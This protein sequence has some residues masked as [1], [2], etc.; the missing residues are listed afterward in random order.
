M[1]NTKG[2]AVGLGCTAAVVVLYL[3]GTLVAER[4]AKEMV[5][6]SIAIIE[7]NIADHGK[8]GKVTYKEVR[9]AKFQLKPMASLI[10]PKI[11]INDPERERDLEIST[12][13]IR[14]Q[15]KTMDM[16]SYVIDLTGDVQFK[17]TA[18]EK[19]SEVV[20]MH[21][22][23]QLAL[24][25]GVAADQTRNYDL[26]HPTELTFT[27]QHPEIKGPMAEEEVIAPAGTVLVT[28]GE[29]PVVSWSEMA[30]GTPL[31]QNA[32]YRQVNVKINNLDFATLET[33]S[34]VNKYANEEA[35]RQ[36]MD[37]VAMLE[38]L[39]LADDGAKAFNPI[40][41]VNEFTLSSPVHRNGEQGAPTDETI[42]WNIK[43]IAWMSGLLSV[44]MNGELHYL[45]KDESMPYGAL[46]L[47]LV[48]SDKIL[49][50]AEEQYPDAKD[51]S[52]SVK[53]AL[54]RLS[55]T[56]IA[57]GTT[58]SIEV[59]REKNGRLQ[60]GKLSLEEA[61]AMVIGLFMHAPDVTKAPEAPAEVPVAPAT[62]APAAAPTTPA[63]EAPASPV[64]EVP[65][66]PAAVPPAVEAPTAEAPAAPAEVPADADAFGIYIPE[67]GKD[68]TQPPA[69]PE[70]SPVEPTNV[71]PAVET[72]APAAQ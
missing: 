1:K 72:P 28:F 56:E 67:Q 57:P 48:D 47:R 9:I 39:R 37:V 29:R 49:A 36:S 53:E 40:S 20:V 14:Y 5:D 13:E 60:I 6:R 55:G 59:N 68:A 69:A 18:A 54:S 25:V 26:Y 46:T 64:A 66:A 38:N 10:E 43:N 30:D 50:Y 65:A 12:P 15:P 32:V 11:S 61:L 3:V 71:P 44:Y 17:S 41:I 22:N 24:N 45:P 16:Q 21:A 31:N 19:G 70:T 23:E 7:R 42:H 63:P 35:G 62:E 8:T 4:H 52:A 27:K 33:A 2:L 58:L 51:Y 34:F